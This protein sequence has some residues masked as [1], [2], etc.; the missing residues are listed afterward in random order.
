[1]F[2]LTDGSTGVSSGKDHRGR[3]SRGRADEKRRSERVLLESSEETG[4]ELMPRSQRRRFR[5]RRHVKRHPGQE[6]PQAVRT[7]TRSDSDRAAQEL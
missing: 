4:K 2:R 3:R 7:A 5:N 1:M 6:E